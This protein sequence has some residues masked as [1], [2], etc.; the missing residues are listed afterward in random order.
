[1]ISQATRTLERIDIAPVDSPIAVFKVR[2]KYDR[3]ALFSA[4]AST[5]KTQDMIT[6]QALPLVG[7]FDKTH[8]RDIVQKKLIRALK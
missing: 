8:K 5:V 3:P 1:M 7:V 6:S 4:F 2:D